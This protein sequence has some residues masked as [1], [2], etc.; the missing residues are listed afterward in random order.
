MIANLML[1]GLEQRHAPPRSALLSHRLDP[2]AHCFHSDVIFGAPSADCRGTGICK[3]VAHGTLPQGRK[4][5][6][7]R[8]SEALF[9]QGTGGKGVAMYLF[10]ELLCI[11][12]Y[13]NHLRG[14]VL[15]LTEPCHLPRSMVN[16]LKLNIHTLPPGNYPVEMHQ[17]YLR[18]AFS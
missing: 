10:R 1:Y 5:E 11:N 3:I 4:R 9:T 13:K 18:I 15:T 7:C 12:V 14:G 8:V 6:T 2:G 16:Y 17:G